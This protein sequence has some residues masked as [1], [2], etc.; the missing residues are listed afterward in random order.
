M[1]DTWT[2]VLHAFRWRC[3]TCGAINPDTTGTCLRAAQH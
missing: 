1:R 3:E 2:R